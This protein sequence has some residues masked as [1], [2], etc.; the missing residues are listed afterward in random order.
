VNLDEFHRA[1]VAGEDGERGVS[2]VL[3]V[4]RICIRRFGRNRRR[5]VSAGVPKALDD[6]FWFDAR[7][8]HRAEFGELRA[9][10]G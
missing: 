2:D 4:H 5:A 7:P 3:A 6:V 1:L 9:N 8:H 10:V